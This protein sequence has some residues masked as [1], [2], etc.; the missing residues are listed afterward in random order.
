MDVKTP[1]GALLTAKSGDMLI[2]EMD[3]PIDAWPVDAGIFDETYL[4]VALGTCIKRA[5]TWIVPLTVR[6]GFFCWQKA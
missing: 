6:A 3:A 1:W 4:I 2:S 5:F